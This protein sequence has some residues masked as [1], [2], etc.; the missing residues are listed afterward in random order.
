MFLFCNISEYFLFLPQ[1]H[2]PIKRLGYM[3]VKYAGRQRCLCYNLFFYNLASLVYVPNNLDCYLKILKYWV[4]VQPGQLY[5]MGRRCLFS[6]G[7]SHFLLCYHNKNTLWVRS[8]ITSTSL[9]PHILL[10]GSLKLNLIV[11]LYQ[12]R[13]A[14]GGKRWW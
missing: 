7:W 1:I 14:Q 4:G 5:L 2:N 9:T 13:L 6:F 3:N 10:L 12:L 11:L 8:F